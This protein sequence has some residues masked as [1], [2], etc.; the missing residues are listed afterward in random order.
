MRIGNRQ[1]TTG[2]II[3]VA[4]IVA[5][6]LL[7][8]LVF[9]GVLP[10]SR[11]TSS[12]VTLEIWGLF[13][14][15]AVWQ[16]VFE[17]YKKDHN[18]FFNYTKKNPDI[19]ERDLLEAMAS[20]KAPDIIMFHSSWLPKHG[21][22]V[23]P[24]PETLM[25]VRSFQETFPDVATTDFVSQSKIYALPV[26]TDVLTMF[27][28]KDLFNT[29]GIA[30]PP[31]TWDDFIKAIQKLSDKDKDGNLKKSGAA[32][33][34]AANVNNAADILGL[35][36]MQAGA[37]MISNDGA[38]AAFDQ[39]VETGGSTY[40]PGESALRFYTDFSNLKSA[41]YTWNN[42]MP[43][44]LD[45]FASGRTAIVFDYAV[46]VPRIKQKAPNLRLGVAAMP[47]LDNATEAVNYADF[48]GYS[49]PTTSKNADAAWNFLV[50]LTGKNINKYFSETV[51]RPAARR[52]VLAEEQ[53]SP[54]LGVFAENILSAKNWYRANPVATD[55][56]FLDM[57]DAVISGNTKPADAVA[58]AADKVTALM[59]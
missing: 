2:Q 38:Q 26:W 39:S 35:L 11:P 50:F 16:P 1:I 37:K 58:D 44:S 49:V 40:K 54:D 31:K 17:T 20:G 59:R 41:A 25:T 52:D 48:W 12:R 10:G 22:K 15:P 57:I 30:V 18:I 53:T 6:I 36:M 43:D 46:N 3:I 19:Y 21:N 24:L 27:Y 47:Q 13:D 34:A 45:A 8:G 14:E 23:S 28:N 7:L 32:I 9:S 51:L 33:G 55:K 5:I 4:A 42:A 29:A 56:I